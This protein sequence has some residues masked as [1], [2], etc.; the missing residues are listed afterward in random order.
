MVHR[1][2]WISIVKEEGDKQ[3][4]L[5]DR[6]NISISFPRRNHEKID[7]TENMELWEAPGETID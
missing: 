6:A 2:F 7:I 5:M 3:L 1:S 4:N